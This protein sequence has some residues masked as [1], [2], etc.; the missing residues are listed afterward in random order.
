MNWNHNKKR[1]D[2]TEIR[3]KLELLAELQA[4][5]A[6]LEM[7]N[8]E[9]MD[10]HQQLEEAHDR[11]AD[12]YDYAPVGYL[13][14]DEVGDI[15]AIN[16]TGCALLGV[17]RVFI[18][19]KPFINY[20]AK[21][22][23]HKFI[24]SLH[25]TFNSFGNTVVELQIITSS[26]NTKYVRLESLAVEGG[27]TCRMVMADIDELKRT[28]NRNHELLHGNRRLMQNIFKIQEEERR[29]LAR[30]LHDELGQWLTAIN[31][32]TEMIANITDKDHAIQTSSLAISECARK[33]HEVMRDML[34]Q[35]RPALLDTLGLVDALLELKRQWRT[36]HTDI[37]LEFKFEGDLVALGESVNITIYRIVQEAL[38]NICRHANATRA[39]VI[40]RRKTRASATAK[41]LFLTVE[42]NG[43][44]YD[45]GKKSKGF[46]LLGM[47]ERTIAADGKFTI[48]NAPN[49]G[50]QIYVN[51]P[52][53]HSNKKRKRRIDDN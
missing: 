19:G 49:G 35:L 1:F 13:T 12:L 18:V 37:T 28:M 10:T 51:L 33:M 7:H 48:R 8:C 14:L 43:K 36:Y 15:Q 5:Q 24:H 16:L 47:R 17:E 34:H 20:L 27:K 21:G 26:G 40:L 11:Y 6:A 38:N 45:F 22:G 44:G 2:D 3:S 39:L 31:V 50:T 52:L 30:E 32:E 25:Q 46:G 41:S 42:D 53:V 23:S 4:N 9:L 29:L